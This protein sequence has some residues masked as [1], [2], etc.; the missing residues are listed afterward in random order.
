MTVTPLTYDI[1]T[2]RNAAH[3]GTIELEMRYS[4]ALFNFFT[5]WFLSLLGGWIQLYSN[6]PGV[7]NCR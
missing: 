6:F 5:G 3:V 4:D 1:R 2:S 7:N